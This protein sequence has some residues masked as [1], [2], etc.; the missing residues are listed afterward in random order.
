MQLITT[1]VNQIGRNWILSLEL[2]INANYFPIN[3][4]IIHSN[5]N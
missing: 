5:L 3:I 4:K 2:A 1:T